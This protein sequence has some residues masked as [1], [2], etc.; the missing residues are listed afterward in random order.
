MDVG[1]LDL[2]LYY[3]KLYINQTVLEERDKCVGKYTKGLGQKNM[4]LCN[5]K[6]DA[7]SMALTVLDR[8]LKNQNLHYDDIGRLEVGTESNYDKS[9]SIKSHLMQLFEYNDIVGIDNINACYG[10]T[11]ALM[12]C[13]NWIRSTN[14]DK[15]AVVVCTDI[16]TYK[17]GSAIA[18]GG[19][20]AIAMLIGCNSAAII[21]DY[22]VNYF[23]NSW[24]F[25][26]PVKEEFP[27]INGKESLE[28]Y[29]KCAKNCFNNYNSSDFDYMCFHTPYIKLVEKTAKSLDIPFEKIEPSLELSK[30]IGNIYNGSLYL[31]LAS[32]VNNVDLENKRVLMFSYGSGYASTLFS[33]DF[34]NDITKK[35]EIKDRLEVKDINNL[36][37]DTYQGIYIIDTIE[38]SRR[39]YKKI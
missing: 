18:T 32:L 33:I 28:L 22:S 17:E 38:N 29:M 8:L 13:I 4:S 6:E 9:K 5:D 26:K 39:I 19:A 16:A 10:G 23:G 27:I 34:L 20:G 2:E 30:Q 31:C 12:N 36:P 25:Y 15:Y 3:P 21:N 1:I 35:Y 11:Q 7:V 37:D 24:D 14:T